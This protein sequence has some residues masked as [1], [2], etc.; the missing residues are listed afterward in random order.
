MQH[1]AGDMYMDED[2]ETAL[3]ASMKAITSAG[4]PGPCQCMQGR[5]SKQC[6]HRPL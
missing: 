3:G 5:A 6:W 1:T 4:S 2:E